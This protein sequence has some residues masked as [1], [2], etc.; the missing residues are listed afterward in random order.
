MCLGIISGLAARA[1]GSEQAQGDGGQVNFQALDKFIAQACH[2]EQVNGDPARAAIFATCARTQAAVFNLHLGIQIALAKLSAAEAEAAKTKC[3]VEDAA[4]DPTRLGAA[5]ACLETGVAPQ[6]LEPAS[7][8][9][10]QHLR[11]EKQPSAAIGMMATVPGGTG[12][13]LEQPAPDKNKA[14]GAEETKPSK[15]ETNSTYAVGQHVGTSAYR[16]TSTCKR[17]T[18]EA[19][20]NG[21]VTKDPDVIGVRR[22]IMSPQEASDDYGRRLGKRFI[23]YQVRV[24]NFSKDFQYV[25]HDISLNLDGILPTTYG[26]FDRYGKELPLEAFQAA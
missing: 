10:A 22:S 16:T 7:P 25:V 19:D 21:M 4:G 24:S 2:Q 11:L 9:A 18:A 26:R 5:L 15:S 23:V 17:S 6:S 14:G 12:A 8:A 13:T 20:D 3:S 1:V